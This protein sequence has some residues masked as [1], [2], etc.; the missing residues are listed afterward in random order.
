VVAAVVDLGRDVADGDVLRSKV[1]VQEN[2]ASDLCKENVLRP[3]L[4]Y[5]VR[6][7]PRRLELKGRKIECY[8]GT[9]W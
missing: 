6:L 3:F 9:G 2:F 7:P 4:L 5:R 8:H 1:V